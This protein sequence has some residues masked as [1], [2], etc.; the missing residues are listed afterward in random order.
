MTITLSN[1]VYEGIVSERSLLTMHPDYFLLTGG[2]EQALYR[3]ARKHAGQQ[4]GGWTCRVELLREK[5]GSDSTVG[6]FNRMLRKLIEADQLPEYTLSM[7]KTGEG[8]PA[9]L[10]ELRGAAEAAELHA[11]LEADRERRERA[12]A[13]RRRTQEVDALMDRLARGQRA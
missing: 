13:E 4:R 11:K 7:T 10:F 12:E 6:E 2:L 8:A 1:W 5:T 3:V 9:V